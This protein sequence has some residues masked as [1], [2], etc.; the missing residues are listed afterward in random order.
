MGPLA[1]GRVTNIAAVVG[2]AVILLLNIVL[3]IQTL[4]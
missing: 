2:T 1:N 3:I 4:L